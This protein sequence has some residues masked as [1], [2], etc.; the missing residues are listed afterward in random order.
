MPDV[1]LKFRLSSL[2]V[3]ITFNARAHNARAVFSQSAT[4]PGSLADALRLACGSYHVPSEQPFDDY[5]EA[6][7]DI[8][9]HSI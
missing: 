6:P 1:P 9:R 7:C 2:P 5:P 8:F 3:G 4:Q